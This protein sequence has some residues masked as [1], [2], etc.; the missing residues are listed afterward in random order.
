METITLAGHGTVRRYLLSRPDVPDLRANFRFPV[1]IFLHGTGGTAEWADTETDWS[2]LARRERFVLVV[3]EGVPPN[4][5]KAPKFLTNPSRWNDGSTELG[6]ALHT[7]AADVDFLTAVIQDLIQ[8]GLGDPRR[9]YLTGFSNGAGMTFRFAAERAELVTAIAPVAGYCWVRDPKPA[10][11]L[12]ALL[13]L[14]QRC[15]DGFAQ[16]S[17]V[18]PTD[19]PLIAVHQLLRDDGTFAWIV[20]LPGTSAWPGPGVS[21]NPADTAGNLHSVAGDATAYQQAVECAG[22]ESRRG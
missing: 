20:D 18:T 6:Q 10:R 16:N 22:E 11:D 14:L 5:T 2:A 9:V 3:P 13:T 7:D 15:N 19:Q 12:G 4:P 17:A 1:V 8:R 21:H